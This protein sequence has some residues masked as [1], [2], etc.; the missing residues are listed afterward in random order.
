MT[1]KK[2]SIALIIGVLLFIAGLGGIFSGHILSGIF[3]I[4]SSLICLPPVINF[5]EEKINFKIPN[6]I[7]IILVL[8]FLLIG[9]ALDKNNTISLKENKS[10]VRDTIAEKKIIEDSL[11]NIK[12]ALEENKKEKIWENTTKAGALYKTHD[13]WSKEDCENVV[14]NKIWIGMSIDMLKYE[15]GNP[16][17]ANPS[18]YGNGVKWQ[19][20]WEGFTPSCF[21]GNENGIVTGY[22]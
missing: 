3:M 18:N 22:N 15:R 14:Q 2:T 4:I 8:I 9:S 5:V 7:K 12:I 6:F 19:W 1:N 21:Y 16:T 13:T 20:C 11:K 17:L 10:I